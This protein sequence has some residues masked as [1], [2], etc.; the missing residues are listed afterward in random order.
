MAADVVD[1]DQ[2]ETGQRREG[3]YFGILNLGEKLAAGGALLLSGVLVNLFGA[4]SGV[5]G[6]STV[7]GPAA[8]RFIGNLYGT[9]PA[10]ALIVAA[11]VLLPYHLDRRTLRSIQDQL[12]G[13][14]LTRDASVR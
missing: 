7:H 5:P 3:M 11:L 1:Q 9:I 14:S 2:L 6:G 12:R 8:P 10:I 4:L 13:R